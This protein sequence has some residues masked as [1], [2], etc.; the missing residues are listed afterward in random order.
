M[1]ILKLSLEDLFEHEEFTLIAIHCDLEQYRI[2][3]LLNKHLKTVLK[4]E[5]ID[6]VDIKQNTNYALFEYLDINADIIYN[7]VANHCK[8]STEK[9]IHST[10]LFSKEKNNSETTYY[11]I[12]EQKKVTYFLKI[13]TV[14]TSAKTQVILNKI[15]EI[16][17]VITAY[18]LNA[19]NLKSKN[20]LIFH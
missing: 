6:V 10:N 17:Q 15:L 2:A 4:R 19:E 20:N 1:A 3:Y 16:P 5:Y 9:T 12:P 8:I 18:Y 14:L 7:L 11:L 13:N